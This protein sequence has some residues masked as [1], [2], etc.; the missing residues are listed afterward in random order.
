LSWENG[1]C[2]WQERTTNLYLGNTHLSTH[3]SF[4]EPLLARSALISKKAPKK[5]D[6]FSTNSI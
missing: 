5:K 3:F 4:L 6:I 2:C 1:E